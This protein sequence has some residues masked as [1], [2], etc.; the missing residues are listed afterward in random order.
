MLCVVVPSACIVVACRAPSVDACVAIVAYCS[1]SSSCVLLCAQW[2]LL[3][4]TWIVEPGLFVA[5]PLPWKKFKLPIVHLWLT[6]SCIVFLLGS[7]SCRHCLDPRALQQS[8]VHVLLMY[9]VHQVSQSFV[10]TISTISTI[11][12]YLSIYLSIY[13]SFFLSIYLSIYLSTLSIGY[14]FWSIS[15][16]AYWFLFF[17][18]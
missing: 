14:W 8:T 16:K 13:L 11:S 1:T 17:F 6:L 5:A 15:W 10:S 3:C 18:Q 2:C 7:A 12:T 4:L 9:I